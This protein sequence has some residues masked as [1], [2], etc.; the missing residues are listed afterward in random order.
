MGPQISNIQDGR[1][2]LHP[3]PPPARAAPNPP[4]T[5]PT[6]HPPTPPP[7]RRQGGVLG[8]ACLVLWVLTAQ[9]AKYC[10]V[11]LAADDRGQGG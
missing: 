1:I 2:S 3:P 4:P 6:P 5:T 11:V 10:G 9:A 7:V 8:A